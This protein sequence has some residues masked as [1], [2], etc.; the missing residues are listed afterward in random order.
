ME[1]KEDVYVIYWHKS[2]GAWRWKNVSRER[3]WA[4]TIADDSLKEYG[5]AC[6]ELHSHPPGAI[7]FSRVDDLDES[8]KF[9]IFAILVDIHDNPQIHFRCGIYDKF[10]QIP[11]AWVS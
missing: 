6:I 11:A 5:E 10:F 1:F 7:H 8:G 3:R 9:R 2:E 4:A